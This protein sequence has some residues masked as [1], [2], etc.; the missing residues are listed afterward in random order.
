MRQSGLPT[1]RSYLFCAFLLRVNFCS[2]LLLVEESLR[3]GLG[4]QTPC[5]K[6]QKKNQSAPAHLP[7]LGKPSGPLMAV[8][9]RKLSQARQTQADRRGNRPNASSGRTESEW[10]R[11]PLACLLPGMQG[12][13]AQEN[14]VGG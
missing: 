10:V 9:Y 7:S 13:G 6:D 5:V 12:P 14:V 8:H 11:R 1:F 4:K 3:L 2:K